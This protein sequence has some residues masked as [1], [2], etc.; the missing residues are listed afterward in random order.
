MTERTIWDGNK[1]TTETE[2]DHDIRELEKLFI[3]YKI[4]KCPSTLVIFESLW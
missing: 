3:T 4:G 1:T 2:E